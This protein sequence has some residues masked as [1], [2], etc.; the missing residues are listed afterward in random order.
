MDIIVVDISQMKSNLAWELQLCGSLGLDDRLVYLASAEQEQ[1]ALAALYQDSLGLRIDAGKV[2]LYGRRGITDKRSLRRA[3]DA[4]LVQRQSR[5][6]G[7]AAGRQSWA[8]AAVAC[9]SLGFYPLLPLAFY[10]ETSQDTWRYSLPFWSPWSGDWPQVMEVVNAPALAMFGF[11]VFTLL[12]LAWAGRRSR[13]VRVLVPFQ[14]VV[15]LLTA[16]GYFPSAFLY[17][18]GR[19]ESFFG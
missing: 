3:I 7:V 11:G 17:L 8:I 6:D 15:V 13:A 4:V 10:P 12:L 19:V 18:F 2:C 1:A 14:C 9:F 16:F 5:V